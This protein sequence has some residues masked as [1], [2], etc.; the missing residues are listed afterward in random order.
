MEPTFEA[1]RHAREE[2]Q[3]NRFAQAV[4]EVISEIKSQNDPFF[5]EITTQFG[6][7]LLEDDPQWSLHC[8]EGIANSVK[9]LEQKQKS[10]SK[11]LGLVGR[12]QPFVSSLSMYTK[13]FDVALQAGPAPAAIIY[14]GAR[15]VLQAS[16]PLFW[17][18]KCLTD[19]YPSN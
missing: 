6:A 16:L 8:A 3:K 2:Y 7:S 18:L 14:G 12:L 11:T 9:S 19:S 17:H 4:E 5:K 1:R 10:D 15:L 13:A